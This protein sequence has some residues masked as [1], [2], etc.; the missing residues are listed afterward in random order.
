MFVEEGPGTSTEDETDNDE[1]EN[2]LSDAIRQ[3]IEEN[4]NT[5]TAGAKSGDD[6]KDKQN[7]TEDS[8]N[9][10]D[11]TNDDEDGYVTAEED[12]ADT[13]ES[14]DDAKKA[15]DN[16]SNKEDLEKVESMSRSSKDTESVET[17]SDDSWKTAETEINKIN[18]KESKAGGM[19]IKQ[20]DPMD[21]SDDA[22]N[23]YVYDKGADSDEFS[24]VE[25]TAADEESDVIQMRDIRNQMSNGKDSTI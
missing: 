3:A 16:Q 22:S 18:A 6:S 25:D 12:N 13:A 15:V 8:K 20:C 24:D 2:Q 10:A 1:R 23:E 21:K 4:L 17:S 19:E 14:L 9:K 11:D 7:K 5:E